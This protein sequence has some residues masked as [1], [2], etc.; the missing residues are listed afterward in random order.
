MISINP[1]TLGRTVS[2]FRPEYLSTLWIDFV[3][4]SVQY[5]HLS[6]CSE[7]QQR[8]ITAIISMFS[9]VDTACPW[10]THPSG[11]RPKTKAFSNPYPLTVKKMT[12]Y[13]PQFRQTSFVSSKEDLNT[14][15]SAF[16][17]SLDCN[18][19]LF[20]NSSAQTQQHTRENGGSRSIFSPVSEQRDVTPGW[21]T[22]AV[23][24]HWG[25][26]SLYDQGAH[27]PSIS[28]R[29]REKGELPSTQTHFTF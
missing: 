16:L 28:W 25:H 10:K 9:H 23:V 1:S 5:I 27:P 7:K 21:P 22:L 4:Q 11:R 14:I 12:L 13:T 20:P 17:V 3:C 15:P 8:K 19:S 6:C 18:T 26:N 2:L 24:S 29:H